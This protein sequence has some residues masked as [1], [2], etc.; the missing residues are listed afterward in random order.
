MPRPIIATVDL[1]ALASNLSIVRRHAR[2]ARVW[3]VV[4]AN[5]Y[6][7][8]L[9]AVWRGLQKTDGFALLDLNEAILLRNIGW[10][11]PILLLEGFFKPADLKDIDRYRLTTVVHNDWQIDA[12]RSITPHAPLNIYLKLNSG[13]NRLGF[14]DRA[15]PDAWQA[16]SKLKQVATLTLMT[17]FAYADMPEG[18]EAQMAVVTRAGAGLVGPRC[19]ANSAATLWYPETHGQW[20]RPGIMLYGASPSGDWQ[21]I[22]TSG[23]KPVMTLQSEL[24]AV[25]AVP[26]GGRIGYGGRH[27]ISKSQRIGGVACGYADGYPR[28]APTGTPIFVDGFRTRTLGTVSMD[29]LMVDLQPCPLARIGSKVEL[30]GHNIKIDEVASAAGTL[31]YELMSAIAPRVAVR[32]RY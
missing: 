20:I 27:Q 32:L 12:L 17:H 19:L 10:L 1:A 14:S 13:M 29:M 15:L 4:K 31:S 25:Q 6:G 18:V 24:I 2:C 30:W 7:H 9:H 3:S 28:H 22:S 21:D 23:L 8:G 5:G 26:S 11:G 16:L